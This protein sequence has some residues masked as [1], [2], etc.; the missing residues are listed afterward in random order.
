MFAL[1]VIR[2]GSRG[3]RDATLSVG[4]IEP[5]TGA[6]YDLA[7]KRVVRPAQDQ[8]VALASGGGAWV[9]PEL[10]T[11]SLP[12]AVRANGALLPLRR[13]RPIESQFVT[14]YTTYAREAALFWRE[15]GVSAQAVLAAGVFSLASVQTPIRQTLKLMALLTPH[16]VEGHLPDAETLERMCVTAG[17]GLQ[18]NRPRWFTAFAEYVPQIVARA[19]E[20]RLLDNPLRRD[21][22]MHAPLPDGLSVTKLSFILA[23]LGSNLGCLDARILRWAYGDDFARVAA[24]IS[25]KAPDGTLTDGT[26]GRYVLA[27][28]KILTGVPYYDPDDPVALARAQWLLWEQLGEEGPEAHDHE[29]I[30]AAVVDR[31]FARWL[32]L[33]NNG[34]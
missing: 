29:E 14:G 5:G 32:T 27:E 20:R 10:R 1:H 33:R 9:G 30:F 28:R 31:R 23:L 7:A 21:L 17:V 13:R 2:G 8:I 22:C 18:H 4:V 15:H 3:L 11:A 25:R 12:A 34:R 16:V 19:N 26:Y 24:S 6:V